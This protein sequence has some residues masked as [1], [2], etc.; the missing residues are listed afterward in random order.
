MEIKQH[1][2]VNQE[3]KKDYQKWLTRDNQTCY[4]SSRK[5]QTN[6]LNQKG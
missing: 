5:E 1:C 3:R 4:I 2:T 6:K